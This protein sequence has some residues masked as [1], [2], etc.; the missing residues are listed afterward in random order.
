MSARASLRRRL[1]LAGAI[2]IAVAT[3]AAVLLL[4]AAFE[5]TALRSLDR[6]LDEDLDRLIALAGAGADGRPHLTREPLDERY[7][8]VFSGW[9]WAVELPDGVRVSR[10]AW[11]AASFEPLLAAATAARR[12]HEAEGPRAQPLRVATQRVLLAGATSPTAFA[13]AGNLADVRADAGD[14]RWLAGGAFASIALAL[15]A[16]IAWQ[17]GFG[18]RPLRRVATTLERMQHDAGVRFADGNLPAEVAPLA[19]QVNRLLDDHARRVERAGRAAADLAHAL[20]TPLAALSLESRTRGDDFARR[21]ATEVD[22]M[23]VAVERHLGG[24]GEVDTRQRVAALEVAQALEA[25]MRRVHAARGLSIEVEGDPALRFA[26]RR[27]DLEEMLGNLLDNA[28]KWARSR[29]RVRITAHGAG[30]GLQVDDDGPGL[31][32]G[33]HGLA[34]QRG[35]RLDQRAPGSGLGLAIVEDLASAH[36][37]VLRLGRSELGGLCATL[38]FEAPA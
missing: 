36:G 22:R 29:V 5:R 15:L 16:V 38:A 17:V 25:L 26:G 37:G 34:L 20:K 6:R 4:G 24:R 1:L 3:F 21:V 35:V 10:S 7:D 30:I 14:F 8:R 19:V 12:H 9:Y 33:Q 18:L 11:D 28:C 27:E 32:P 13:V 23:Q 31:D 2:G